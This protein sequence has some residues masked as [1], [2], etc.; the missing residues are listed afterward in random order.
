MWETAK[1]SY[2]TS[3]C[4]FMLRWNMMFLQKE[5]TIHLAV[6][7]YM[8]ATLL[9]VSNTVK[10]ERNPPNDLYINSMV[11]FPYKHHWLTEPFTRRGGVLCPPPCTPSEW[12]TLKAVGKGLV[13]TS[14]ACGWEPTRL[15][16]PPLL[17]DGMN[18]TTTPAP[19]NC[20]DRIQQLNRHNIL[21][22]INMQM[23]EWLHNAGVGGTQTWHSRLIVY[24][25]CY[26][27]NFRLS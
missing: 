14:Q 23:C 15:Q 27:A 19:P 20:Y 18:Q 4:L 3:G 10:T 17:T 11:C 13:V 6:V 12:V 9:G 1:M 8:P 26:M 21:T 16:L 24:M 5:Y 2:C 22:G 25:S 7:S